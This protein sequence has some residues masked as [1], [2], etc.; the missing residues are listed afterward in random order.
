M[1]VREWL[2]RRKDIHEAFYE[3]LVGTAGCGPFDGGCVVVAEA[4][5]SVIGGEIVVLVRSGTDRADHAAVL[6]DGKLWDFD[7]PSTPA[8][9]IRRFE[10]NELSH[11]QA[12]CS[13]FRPIRDGDLE[14]ACRDPDLR[15][16]LAV[17]LR[18]VLHETADQI[19]SIF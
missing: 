10:R 13:G 18:D 15:D 9:F 5:H 16:R 17:L 14:D 2:A 6:L 12:S 19:P 1:N 8:V 11:K 4:L 7:G 3:E